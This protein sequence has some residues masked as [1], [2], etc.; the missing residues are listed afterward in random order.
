MSGRRT[1]FTSVPCGLIGQQVSVRADGTLV[2][3]Y[4]RGQVVRTHP[5]QPA[6]GRVSDPAD[7]PPGTGVYARRD[8][9]KLAKMAAARSEA[10]G[11]YA[12]R[13]L[14]IPRTFGWWMLHRRLVRDYETPPER[15]GAMI[16]WAMIG[17]LCTTRGAVV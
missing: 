15:S 2:K 17:I 13:I 14:D 8:V 3:I 11:I 16:H 4:H 6:G 12:K 9:G 5:Q 7:F 10:I 1:R